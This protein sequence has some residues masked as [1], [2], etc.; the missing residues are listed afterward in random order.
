VDVRLGP[1]LCVRARP[2]SGPENAVA[3]GNRRCFAS[4]GKGSSDIFGGTKV[5]DRTASSPGAPKAAGLI[6]NP[7]DFYGGLVLLIIAAIAWWATRALPG[8]QGF[9]FGPGTA[10]RLFII[11]LG[12]NAFAIMVHG[13]IVPGP[14]MSAYHWR[15]PLF[16][17]AAVLVFAVTI[18]PLGLVI[19]SFATVI[20]GSAATPEV[21]WI[22]TVIWAAVLAAFCAFLFPY[23]LNLPMQLWPPRGTLPG[24]W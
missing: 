22:Q 2:G 9:A 11:L 7:Q 13:L 20:V 14:H 10:P 15:G 8:Q 1:R 6:K 5:T 16:I 24:V 17:T 21:R 23:V 19:A 18:R 12:L 4:E 3:F